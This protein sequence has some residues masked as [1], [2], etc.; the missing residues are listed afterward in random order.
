MNIQSTRDISTLGRWLQAGCRWFNG[1]LPV[2]ILYSYA[3]LY[4]YT[5]YDKL[6]HLKTFIKGNK[7]LPYVGEYAVYI[8]WGIPLLEI[9]L[10]VLLILPFITLQRIALS[11]SVVLMGIFTLFLSLMMQFVPDRLCQCG[12]VI[13]SM[14]WTTH[15]I[16]N[17]VW[18]VAGIYALRKLIINKKLKCYEN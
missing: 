6:T 8:G 16:F 17:L 4:M 11:A 15:L 7:S 3:F 10:A 12:G 18:L 2:V 1:R 5:G 13:E 14:G 9:L